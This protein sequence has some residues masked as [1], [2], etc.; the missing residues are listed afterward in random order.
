[1]TAR[2]VLWW[3]LRAAVV[4]ACL[5]FLVVQARE[6]SRQMSLVEWLPASA[7]WY[8]AMAAPVF[9]ATAWMLAAGWRIVLAGLGWHVRY[10]ALART[11][12]LTQIGKYVPGNVGQHVGRVALA[13]R[14]FGLP[15]GA[16][17]SSLLQESALLCLAALLTALA[18]ALALPGALPPVAIGALSIRTLP[19]VAA[20]I[21]AGL[22]A[23]AIVNALSR[24]G[25]PPRSRPLGW[26]Y[27]AT[28]AWPVVARA[29][30]VYVVVSLLNGA[31]LLLLALPLLPS[32]QGL[33]LPL[34]AA[35][36]LSWVIGFVV[37]G[38]P[39]GLGV[40]E[41]ALIFLLDGVLAKETVLAIALMSRLSMTLA[42]ALIFLSGLA[43]PA[44]PPQTETAR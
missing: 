9:A 2:R 26:L 33:F 40:R 31:A 41:A 22:V 11:L 28:P 39:G 4:L 15:V 36:A 43:L 42:D 24:T 27:S 30:S 7:F 19:L 23:L 18:C 38:A 14:E 1:M 37:P 32:A 35:F 12:F 29:A 6:V 5:A 34:T 17:V 8:A 21:A 13:K 10:L 16:C 44:R 25:S 3:L 20:I